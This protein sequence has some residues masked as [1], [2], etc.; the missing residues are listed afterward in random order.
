MSFLFFSA[1]ELPLSATNEYSLSAPGPSKNLFRLFRAMQLGKP[2]LLEGP[3]GVG[4][5]SL[6]T[7]LANA[8]G[9]NIV[10]I[11]LSEHTV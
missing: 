2:L 3:P 9:H 4:K 8:S 1:G 5:T 6:V 11:N 10:R 7:S